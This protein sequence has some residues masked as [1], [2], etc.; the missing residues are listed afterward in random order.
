MKPVYF[1]GHNFVFAEHQPEYIPLPAY[2]VPNDPTFRVVFCWKLSFLERL[3]VLFTGVIW[4]QVLTFNKPLQPQLL[5][6]T[7]ET[8]PR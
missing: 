4:H 5:Q 3:K 2:R 7:D 6:V 1:A 8:V